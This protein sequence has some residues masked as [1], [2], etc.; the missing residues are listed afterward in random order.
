[1]EIASW[2]Q[3]ETAYATRMKFWDVRIQLPVTTVLQPLKTT[4]LALTRPRAM[5]VTATAWQMRM[6]TAYA[7]NLR[8]LDVPTPLRVTTTRPIRKKT[9]VAI[10]AHAVIL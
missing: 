1:M 9:V 8:F 2:I 4:V 3:T 10:S 5:I 7:M 6:E